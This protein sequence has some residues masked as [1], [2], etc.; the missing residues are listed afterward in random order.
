VKMTDT[1]ASLLNQLPTAITTQLFG[2]MLKGVDFV[3]SNVPGAPFPVYLAGAELERNFAFGPLTGAAVNVVLVSHNGVC[4]IGVNADAAAIADLDVFMD[5]L[6]DGFA[7]I[8]TLGASEPEPEPHEH[9]LLA[10]AG[11][12]FTPT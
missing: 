10:P 8:V 2:A 9:E 1:L 11:S 5:A 6:R 3:T 4:C 7:E 12:G